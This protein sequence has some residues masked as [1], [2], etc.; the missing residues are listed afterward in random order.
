[1]LTLRRLVAEH[2]GTYRPVP[3]ELSVLIY[4]ANSIAHLMP[5]DTAAEP[6]R[7]VAV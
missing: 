7:A 1:M 3:A 4:Y 5:T 2:E 6:S